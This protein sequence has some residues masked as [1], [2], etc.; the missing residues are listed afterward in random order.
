[1]ERPAVAVVRGHIFTSWLH[2]YEEH[3]LVVVGSEKTVVFDDG[4]RPA[5][6]IVRRPPGWEE[7]ATVTAMEPEEHRAVPDGEPL[8]AEWRHFLE[9][10]H[11]R[12]R[13]DT[14]GR[15]ALHVLAVL[16]ACQQSLSDHGASVNVEPLVFQA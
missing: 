2:P 4:A 1:M 5:L 6:S 9:C 12:R 14:D 13:P 11:T 8:V 16:D 15:D 7:G 3:R 10:L